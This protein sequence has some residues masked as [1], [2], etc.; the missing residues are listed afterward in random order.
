MSNQLVKVQG[1]YTPVIDD[2]KR[3][4]IRRTFANG[5]PDLEF[6]MFIALCNRTGLDPFA[7][8]IYIIPRNEKRGNEWV[9]KWTPQTSIDGM[10]LIADRTGGYAGSDD[11]VFDSEDGATPKK[12][13]VTV[14][15]MV[16]G[17]RCPFTATARWSEYFQEKSP[18]WSKMPYLM[19]GKCA[20]SLALR[21]AFPQELSGLYTREEMDQA[22]PV[23][24][25]PVVVE[26]DDDGNYAQY[27]TSTGERIIDVSEP[28][29]SPHPMVQQAIDNREANYLAA[30]EGAGSIGE[31]R[32]I[33]EQIAGA[34]IKSDALTEA[35]KKQRAMLEERAA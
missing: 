28:E 18:M 12:A 11:P 14:Y 16:Q 4:L 20:E 30:I 26:Q 27:D 33:G 34:G 21:K 13:S 31:L 23:Q 22:G 8:Q 15:K 2:E 17:Q 3:D 7:R 19:L 24:N 32:K 9:K 5:C 1:E 10:R 25:A 35:Y 29:A 6:E